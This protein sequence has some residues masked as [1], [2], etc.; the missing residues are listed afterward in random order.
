MLDLANEFSLLKLLK[1]VHTT[2]ESEIYQ[3][4]SN[5]IKEGVQFFQKLL[6]RYVIFP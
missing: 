3:T 5:N 2:K 1:N 6:G 4:S